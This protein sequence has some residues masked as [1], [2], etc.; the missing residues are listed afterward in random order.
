MG[1]TESVQELH[2]FAKNAGIKRCWYHA[3][4]FPHYDIH[5]E[6][7][8]LMIQNGAKQI[9]SKEFILSSISRG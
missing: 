9:T 6:K 4:K 5:A 7:V 1:S 3:H 8:Q 2:I